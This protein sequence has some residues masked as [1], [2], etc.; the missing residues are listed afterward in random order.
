MS[1][2]FLY[3]LRLNFIEFAV[4]SLSVSLF[5]SP[6]LAFN[7]LS[8]YSWL[9]CACVKRNHLSQCNHRFF[10]S[11][12]ECVGWF[13]FSCVYRWVGWVNFSGIYFYRALFSINYVAQLSRQFKSLTKVIS[14][15]S[16]F[17]L[18]SLSKRIFSNVYGCRE[19]LIVIKFSPTDARKIPSSIV[20]FFFLSSGWPARFLS[21]FYP[22]F[23]HFLSR[24]LA[25]LIFLLSVW[26][27]PSSI[28]N[29]LR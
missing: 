9:G 13:F 2:V 14:A 17:I 12:R 28:S 29:H 26:L 24:Q 18:S 4:L 19:S 21:T 6:C 16:Q 20:F 25:L 11:K 10:L 15:D 1:S 8:N 22:F 3:L 7:Y 5:L 23:S 27:F